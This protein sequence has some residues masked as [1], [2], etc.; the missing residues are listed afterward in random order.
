MASSG[1]TWRGFTCDTASL[2]GCEL[3][4][5]AA[6]LKIGLFGGQAIRSGAKDS[7]VQELQTV[8]EASASS[9][10]W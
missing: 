4:T 1:V 10:M 9:Q 2:D 6:K 8:R 3:I 7:D 5:L